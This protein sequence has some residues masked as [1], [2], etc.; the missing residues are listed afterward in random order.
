MSALGWLAGRWGGPL[1]ERWNGWVAFGL[2]AILGG[3]ILADGLRSDDADEHEDERVGA[4]LYVALAVAT[5]ID[6]AA[7]GLTLPLLPVAPWLSLTLIGTV[8]AGCSVL[9]FVLGRS[10]GDR[11][12]GKLEIFGGLV[13]IAIGLK[14][15]IAG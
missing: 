2:L 12:G 5:S 11:L 13:L 4:G 8:T 1:I 14:I 3:K 9:G 10:I 6:A 15:L 7:A